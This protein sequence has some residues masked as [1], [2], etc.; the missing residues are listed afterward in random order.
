[1]IRFRFLVPLFIFAV[2]ALGQGEGTE[3]ARIPA[4]TQWL[5]DAAGPTQRAAV[6]SVVLLVCPQDG[7]KGTGF[8]LKNGLVITAA[9]VVGTCNAAQISGSSSMGTPVHFSKLAMDTVKDLAALKPSMPLS[10]GLQLAGDAEPGLGTAVSTWGYPLMYN[11]PAP[12][13]SVGYVSGYIAESDQG[14]QVKHLVVNGAFNPGN[15]GGPLLKAQTDVV[16]GVVVAKYHLFPPIVKQ[17]I[18]ALAN[19]KS[20]FAYPLSDSQ[21]NPLKDQQGNPVTYSEAQI[22]AG[23]LQQ[24]YQTAQVMIGEAVSVSELRAFLKTKEQELGLVASTEQQKH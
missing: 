7:A 5:L 10:G 18:Q 23:I 13:L 16:V 15:S 19:N 21:G 3:D 4:A 12:L 6:K 22:T 1:M 17:A 14:V 24:F 9:H 2:S 8:L 20:G 11:G